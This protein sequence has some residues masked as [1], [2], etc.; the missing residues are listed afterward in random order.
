MMT[1]VDSGEP[2]QE[3]RVHLD[4]KSIT[5]YEISSEKLLDTEGIQLTSDQ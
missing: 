5:F 1:D 4:H 2:L 3:S